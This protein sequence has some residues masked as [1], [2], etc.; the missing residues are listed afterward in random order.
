MSPNLSVNRIALSIFCTRTVRVHSS[1]NLIAPPQ[2]GDN[3][4]VSDE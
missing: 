4:G 1:I 3:L 2:N